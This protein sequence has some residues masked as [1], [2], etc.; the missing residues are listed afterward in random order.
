MDTAQ[1]VTIARLY[2]TVLSAFSIKLRPIGSETDV[3]VK[4]F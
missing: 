4:C 1:V 2:S 3:N